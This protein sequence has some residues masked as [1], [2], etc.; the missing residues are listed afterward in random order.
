MCFAVA[1][2]GRLS[3]MDSPTIERIEERLRELP[4]DKLAVV[5]DFVSYLA[6]VARRRP[7]APRLDTMLASELVLRRDWERPEEDEAWADL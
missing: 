6:D 7:E 2:V 4:P 5:A 1:K 3:A